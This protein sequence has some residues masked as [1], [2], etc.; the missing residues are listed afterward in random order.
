MKVSKE[1]IIGIVLAGGTSRRMGEDKASIRF[2]GI[3]FLDHVCRNL[4]VHC[5]QLIISSNNPQHDRKKYIRIQDTLKDA[6]PLAGILSAMSA[7]DKSNYIV[8]T[9]DSPLVSEELIHYLIDNHDETSIGTVLKSEGKLYPLL[10]IYH[11]DIKPLLEE[12]LNKEERRVMG[13]LDQLNI[14]T[15]EVPKHLKYMIRNF[16]RPE[17]L[18]FLEHYV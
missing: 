3:S 4:E 8:M 16:N 9:V 1:S 11:K 15:L 12:Y 6:G 13:F 10:G 5:D 7:K 14:Q 17:D 2:Q 18:K